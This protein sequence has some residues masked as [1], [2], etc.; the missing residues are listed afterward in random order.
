MAGAPQTQLACQAINS[1]NCAITGVGVTGVNGAAGPTATGPIGAN[2]PYSGTAGHYNVFQGF[3]NGVNSVAWLGVPIDAPGTNAANQLNT[4]VIRITNVRANA[5]LLGVSSTLIPT[6]IV[7]Y[8]SV[9]GSQQVTI[10]NPQQ[11]V[12]FIQPGLVSR[13]QYPNFDP[14]QQLELGVPIVER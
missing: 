8:I 10:N 14:V 11:T 9:N 7:M 1:T 13:Q 12:A 6:Q 4:R 2:G 3:Q 5:C